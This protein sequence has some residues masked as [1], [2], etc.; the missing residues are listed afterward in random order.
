M[1]THN[2]QSRKTSNLKHEAYAILGMLAFV[3]GYLL[4][5]SIPY[6]HVV[7]AI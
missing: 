2:K 3:A 7:G 4:I 5:I 1:K 6:A